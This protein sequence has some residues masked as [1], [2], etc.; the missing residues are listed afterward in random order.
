MIQTEFLY[1]N[2]VKIKYAQYVFLEIYEII[3]LRCKIINFFSLSLST[4]R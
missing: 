3:K 1:L 4:F 2:L